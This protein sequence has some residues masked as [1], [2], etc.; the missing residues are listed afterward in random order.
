MEMTTNNLLSEIQTLKKANDRMSTLEKILKIL[1]KQTYI[2]FSIGNNSSAYPG[3][4]VVCL[5]M[6]NS[7]GIQLFHSY[8]FE[9]SLVKALAFLEDYKK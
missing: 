1:S 8:D 9:Q 4:W 2:H 5:N 7:R 6:M 3:E